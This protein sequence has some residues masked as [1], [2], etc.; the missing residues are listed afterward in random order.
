[1]F[2]IQ[3]TTFWDEHFR[4][5]AFPTFNEMKLANLNLASFTSI[6]KLH[7]GKIFVNIATCLPD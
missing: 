2:I 7:R 5:G 6:K 4:R 3:E 1:M